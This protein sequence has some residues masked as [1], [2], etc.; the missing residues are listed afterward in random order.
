[1]AV[2]SACFFVVVG[3]VLCIG[4]LLKT[5]S[6]LSSLRFSLHFPRSTSSVGGDAESVLDLYTPVAFLPN[7]HVTAIAVAVG[8]VMWG[9]N[10]ARQTNDK[11]VL[12]LTSAL[13]AVALMHFD[14]ECDYGLQ[15]WMLASGSTLLLS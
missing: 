5:P 11:M 9:S 12:A 1:M 6:L 13:M 2:V 8:V 15:Y 4:A 14:S 10:L 7:S 3:A